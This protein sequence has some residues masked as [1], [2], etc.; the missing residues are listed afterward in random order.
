MEKNRVG[1]FFNRHPNGN[2]DVRTDL[3]YLQT[4]DFANT[5]TNVE[6]QQLSTPL[7][8][9]ESKARVIDY[10][11]QKKNVYLKDMGFDIDGRPVGLYIRSNGH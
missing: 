3:Y 7:L 6:G 9:R 1:T 2:V 5:W 11:S 8:V 10:Q 4:T